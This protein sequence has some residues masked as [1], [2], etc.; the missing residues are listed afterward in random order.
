M[1]FAGRQRLRAPAASG[2]AQFATADSRGRPP[3]S[4]ARPS[5]S[6][7]GPAAPGIT[8]G[9]GAAAGAGVGG[10]GPVSPEAKPF[11][12]DFGP[13]GSVRRSHRPV[14]CSGEAAPPRTLAARAPRREAERRWQV[15]LPGDRCS[16]PSK[17]FGAT[18]FAVRP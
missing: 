5:A 8:P 9:A 13:E 12:G 17:S 14:A 11:S 1:V 18:W 6:A 10:A 2:A 3:P 7:P 4:A 16:P 15:G